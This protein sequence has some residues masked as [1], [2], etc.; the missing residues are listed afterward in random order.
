M[1]GLTLAEVARAV[2]GRLVDAPDPE[3]RVSGSVEYDSRKVAPGGLFV[4]FAG[5]RADGHDFAAAAVRDGA[6]GVIATRQVGVPAVLVDD[7]LVA[8]G[9][10]AR[11][12]VDR[13]PDATV[14]GVTGSSGKTSAKDLIA[15]LVTRLGPAVAPPGTFNNELGHP[16]TVLRADERTRHLV[17]EYGARGVGHIRY[18]CEAAPPTLGVVLNVGVAHIGEFGSADAIAKA[19]GELVEALPDAAD[20]GVAVLNAD[21]PRVSA[22]SSRTAARVLRY[23]ESPAADVRAVDVRLDERGRPA[24][25][26]VSPAGE[27]DVRLRL[28]GPHQVGNT[29]AAAAVALE[30]GVS[31]GDLGGA[32]AELALVSE[33]RMDVFDTAGGVT[34]VDDSYNAN[35]GSMAAALQA[36]VA[37]GQRR[38]RWAVLGY[39]AELGRHERAGHE[40][41]GRLAARLGVDRLVVVEDAAAPVL[42]G[43]RSVDDWGGEAVL[44]PDQEAA[45][46]A[47][48]GELAPGDVVLVKGSRYRTW[49][50][51]DALRGDRKQSADALRSEAPR[52]G[53]ALREGTCQ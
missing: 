30:R 8:L 4:A 53:D 28:H 32:M 46:G 40:E 9:R 37:I 12:V 51:A 47:L 41:V 17:L 52:S 25:R 26:L 13:L 38:R 20:G 11:A 45:I 24:Y 29:L 36:L 43:A 3:V 19:K 10:L 21:D 7:P 5:E 23:G 6:V 18:L 34:V 31:I 44:A 49:M 16:Y 15:Q 35:P 2:S 42:D 22:M 50:I 39:M 1:I 27:T 33:R 14:I 48:R